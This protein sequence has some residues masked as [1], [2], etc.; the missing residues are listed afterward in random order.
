M[1][2]FLANRSSTL[3]AL[4]NAEVAA[5]ISGTGF[6][7]SSLATNGVCMVA[8]DQDSGVILRST[9]GIHWERVILTNLSTVEDIVWSGSQF[10]AVGRS[11]SKIYTSPDGIT[12]T[13]R[14][15]AL[16]TRLLRG[17]TF[18][19]GL[20][21]AVSDT[22]T[23]GLT[24]QSSPDGI[25]WTFGNLSSIDG[26]Y[27]VTFGN[28]VFVGVGG[29]GNGVYARSTNG[30][31]WTPGVIR[32]TTTFYRAVAFGNGL[33]VACS[34]ADISTSPDG[35]TWT[36]RF[37]PGRDVF[38][39]IWTGS[40]FVATGG[41]ASPI[42]TSPDGITWT[43]RTSFPITSTI[44]NSLV[45]FGGN[46]YAGSTGGF[47]TRSVDGGVTWVEYGNSGSIFAAIW[48]GSQFVCVGGGS[49]GTFSYTYTTP[50][51]ITYTR[52]NS[53][54]GGSANSVGLF[55]GLKILIGSSSLIA[56]S[57]DAI[58]WTR[59]IAPILNTQLFGVAASPTI[60]VIVGAS[61]R[62]FTSPDGVNWTSRTSGV[63]TSITDVEWFA[64]TGRFIAVGASGVILTSPDGITWTR[65][66][67]IDNLSFNS[68]AV[69]P[70]QITV[71]SSTA[72]GC[73]TSPD[74]IGWTRRSLPDN[75]I[76]GGIWTG[77]YFI[78]RG[79]NVTTSQN[80]IDW[81]AKAGSPSYSLRAASPD[82]ILG[83]VNIGG[84]I[85]PQ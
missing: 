65:I 14:T 19:N 72:S 57:T 44:Q 26:L 31:S 59:Q 38:D 52:R 12:W 39:I 3:Y 84:Y 18:G 41:G 25:T 76:N 43:T 79:A 40:Q 45:S 47:I 54:P 36:S 7:I 11:G 71:T 48:D 60:A 6:T 68:V 50:D 21:V 78:Y 16:D 58:N 56:T 37:N 22:T 46:L 15:P 20:F 80:G 81:V 83:T 53:V 73:Y 77:K 17:V 63:S 74:G 42:F 85:I 27:D 9:N 34:S 2:T 49:D 24:V 66:T 13:P 75:A 33:F 51:G 62:I 35:I 5:P 32:T 28:G 10:V 8:G 29:N 4:N 69:A 61:G 55:N 70:N 64:P 30:T 67:P 1:G 23:S 82:R